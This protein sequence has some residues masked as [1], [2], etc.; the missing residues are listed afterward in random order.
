MSQVLLRSSSFLFVM[1]LGAVL[2]QTGFFGPKDY[3]IPMKLVLNIT[4]PAA[5]ITSFASYRPVANGMTVLPF[6]SWLSMNVLMIRGARSH[7]IG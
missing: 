5:V 2:R 1:L 6:R 7:Q 3:V 4:L